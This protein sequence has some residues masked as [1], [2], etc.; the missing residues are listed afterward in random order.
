MP[1]TE[2]VR[3]IWPFLLIT[4]KRIIFLRIHKKHI[5]VLREIK[6]IYKKTK[7]KREDGIKV[8]TELS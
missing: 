4:N 2:G 7:R 8:R 1:G 5:F 6:V 3:Q